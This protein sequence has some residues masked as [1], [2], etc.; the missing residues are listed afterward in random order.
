MRDEFVI[1]ITIIG[2]L[3]CLYFTELGEEHPKTKQGVSSLAQE[4]PRKVKT[5]IHNRTSP[6]VDSYPL[7]E[8]DIYTEAIEP[9]MEDEP[10]WDGPAALTGIPYNLFSDPRGFIRQA[11]YCDFFDA[12]P[13]GCFNFMGREYRAHDGAMERYGFY[14]RFPN[15]QPLFDASWSK[16]NLVGDLGE[17]TPLKTAILTDAFD[18]L[19]SAGESGFHLD[20]EERILDGQASPASEDYFL[21]IAVGLKM[22][23]LSPLEPYY[24]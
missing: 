7:R 9:S 14:D 15:T 18:T 16:Y 13:M 6:I 17:D 22:A 10:D 19:V 24:E 1:P 8:E 21:Q 11:P 5:P 4:A 23:N 3:G 20:E 2:I 12:Y